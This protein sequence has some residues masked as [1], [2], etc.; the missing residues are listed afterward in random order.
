MFRTD[1]TPNRFIAA[2][3]TLLA[4]V[5]TRL[6]SEAATQ[7]AVVTCGDKVKRVLEFTSQYDEI[8]E[9][10]QKVDVGGKSPLGDALGVAVQMLIGEM[11]KAGARIPRIL[12]VSDGKSSKT[13]IDPVTIA[14]LC[15]GLNIYID[16]IR[17]GAVEHFNIL[18]RL[19]QMTNGQFF[20]SNDAADMV[21]TA[22]KLAEHPAAS[23]SVFDKDDAKFAPLLG[24]IAGNLISISDMNQD[25][26][27]IINNILGKNAEK[28]VICFS[29]NDPVTKA[30]FNV[31]GRYC[32]NCNNPMHISCAAMWAEQDTKR[33][34][35]EIFRCPHCFYLLK[36]PGEVAKARQLHKQM[37]STESNAAPSS[38]GERVVPTKRAMAR[39]FGDTAMY[40]A[41][42]VCHNIF[43]EDD[44][45]VAC[46]NED[47]NAIYHENCFP[48]LEGGRCKKCGLKF[49]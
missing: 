22:I 49:K 6:K 5:Q 32:P 2:K 28:C 12:L 1:Y 38:D 10:L 39:E 23:N 14:K 21:A 3:K 48:K 41:C 16:V 11:R 15:G 18:K 27:S 30:P 24:Q 34:S 44:P 4:F 13:S 40:S 26:R 33:T 46:G 42:P 25:Q 20:Y 43:E 29:T 19:S 47:C 36:I 35:K 37:K 7:V 17:L 31:S 9:S 45:V 8:E